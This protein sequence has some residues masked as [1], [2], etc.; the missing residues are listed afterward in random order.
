MTH[1]EKLRRI[2]ERLFAAQ[3]MGKEEKTRSQRLRVALVRLLSTLKAEAE[4]ALREL[5][6][7]SRTGER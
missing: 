6:E 1:E 7:V 2:N 4:A 3:N 5:R